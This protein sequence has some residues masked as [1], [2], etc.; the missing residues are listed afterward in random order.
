MAPVESIWN[1]ISLWHWK[2]REG[3]FLMTGIYTFRTS[4]MPS[5]FSMRSVSYEAGCYH[6]NWISYLTFYFSYQSI[7]KHTSLKEAKRIFYQC[8]FQ[9][10]NIWKAKNLIWNENEYVNQAN[11]VLFEWMPVWIGISLWKP[12][13]TQKVMIQ[14]NLGITIHFIHVPWQWLVIV[15]GDSR[16]M[17]RCMSCSEIWNCLLLKMMK[18]NCWMTLVRIL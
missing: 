15:I 9:E 4:R 13:T 5:L 6:G 16:E 14:Y 18:K 7:I 10:T 1:M 11:A 2:H 12:K 3:F 8:G 17:Q